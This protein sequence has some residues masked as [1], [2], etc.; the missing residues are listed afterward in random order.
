MAEQ[1]LADEFRVKKG[2]KKYP[3]MCVDNFYKNP[4]E[5]RKLALDNDFFHNDGH[6]PGKRTS[7]I[8]QINRNFYDKF[9]A[10]LLSLFYPLDKS[11]HYT[12]DT[13]FQLVEQLDKDPNSSKNKGWIHTD[14]FVLFSGII[15]LSP[16]SI[17]ENGTSLFR[18]VNENT[19]NHFV[20]SKILLYRDNID[21]QHDL[22]LDLHNSSFEETVRFNNIYNRLVCFPGDTWHGVNSFNNPSGEPRL[23]QVFFVRECV[24]PYM[25]PVTRCNEQNDL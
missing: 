22:A 3:Y 25:S 20:E 18:V 6:W 11:V 4:D 7:L 21:V 15:Y 17:P 12:I 13:M 5:V 19:I 14:D 23:T 8:H 16:N 1:H 2:L 10:K 9:C 24:S